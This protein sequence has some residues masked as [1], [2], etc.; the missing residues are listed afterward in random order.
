MGI[1]AKKPFG[2]AD[3]FV[4]EAPLY[5]ERLLE[6]WDDA[7]RFINKSERVTIRGHCQHCKAVSTYMKLGGVEVGVKPSFNRGPVLDGGVTKTEYYGPDQLKP[8]FGIIYFYCNINSAHSIAIVVSVSKTHVVKIGQYPSFAD[9]AK[10]ED[11]AIIEALPA[12]DKQ[13]YRRA[14]NLA[15]HG[16]GIGAFVYV[17]RIFER[18]IRRTFDAHKQEQG[19]ADEVFPM[20][21]EKRIELLREYLPEWVV[22]NRKFYNVVSEGIHSLDEADCIA[23]FPIMRS[24]IVM[25]VD[26]N[27]KR[28]ATEARKKALSDQLTKI[29]G[30]NPDTKT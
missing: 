9:I 3:S 24:T 5:E 10:D 2:K 15:A 12:L 8:Q 14:T 7:R 18:L 13:E 28:K 16:F 23:Q 25:M 27:E 19:W 21:M 29:Q 17:R 30:A 6:P 1:V 20:F 4:F 22:Q 26:E 11:V